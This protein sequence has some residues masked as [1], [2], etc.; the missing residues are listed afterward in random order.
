MNPF[1]Q[2]HQEKIAGVLTCFDRVVIMGTLPEIC[3]AGA[4]AGYLTGQHVRLFDYP[5][6]AEPFRDELRAHAELVAAEAGLTIEF[7]R[8]HDAF[9]KEARIKA[10]LAERGDHPGLVHIF[11][12]MEAC[13][14]FKPW[15]DK[16][17]HRTSLKPTQGKCLHYY[18]YFIDEL[19]GLCYVRVPTWAPFRLQIYFNGHYWLARH[20]D[21]AGIGYQM[22]ENAFL[23]LDDVERAQ[24][25]A[26]RFNLKALHRRLERWARAYC[27][28]VRHFR[29]GYHWSL[30][31][32][33]LATDVLFHRQSDLQPLYEALVRT[34]VHAV[35]ADT[36]ATFL[37]RKLTAAYSDELG[38]DF[39]TRIQGTRIRHSMGPTSLKLY[40]KAGLIL[41]VE[42]TTNDVAFFKHHRWVEQRDGYQ[43]WKLA[44]LK[45]TIYSLN[46]LRKLMHAANER[47]LAFLAAIDN[48]DAGLKAIDKVAKPAADH[49]RSYRGFNL[50]LDQDYRL[51]L[52]I[53]R[54]EWAISGFRAADLRAYLPELTPSRSSHLL[55]RLRLHG[56]IKKIGHRYKY[57]LTKLGRRVIA[58]TLAIR[59]F[60]VLPTLCT[61]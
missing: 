43:V 56:L 59:E 30:M 40:D 11:S 54:G 52:T 9:R 7:I 45:K 57:Y 20:L 13:T 47:Y 27:P 26:E 10:I 42:C 29:A 44:P 33:E 38:N 14:S 22:A 31:Q 8:R 53:A 55:K 15:H 6:W 61:V 3:H 41:R 28:V 18:F 2:R 24:A 60:V 34:A 39:H 19:F 51:F 12:A 16:S 46:T 17:T 1:V 58:T 21:K 37:G 5:R 35:K 23:R 25:I 48:P 32:V 4:L 50:L 49:G 36:V